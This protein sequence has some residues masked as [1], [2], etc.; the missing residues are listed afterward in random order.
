MGAAKLFEGKFVLVTGASTGIGRCVA[1]DYAREGAE[2]ILA[3]R[4]EDK[5]NRLKEEI[6]A[7]GRRAVVL[8][9]DLSRP[10]E[11]AKLMD[12]ALEGCRRIDIL[13]NNAG[14]GYVEVVPDVDFEKARRMFEINFWSAVEATQRIL[15]HMLKRGS[16]QIINV[17]SIAGKR[18]LPA[19]S[20]YNASKFALEGFTEAL[21]V[22]LYRS[23]IQV[24]SICPSV[25][26]TP[27]FEHPY[28]KD[29][30]LREQSHSLP[31]MSPESVSRGLLRASKKGKRDVHFTWLGWLAVRLNPLMPRLLDWI[32]FRMRGEKVAK[33][34][35][36]IIERSR[37]DS[38]MGS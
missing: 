13:V 19:S 30:P 4:S 29:S 15:P 1:L 24:I 38:G 25:T 12:R 2:L 35:A 14:V 10:G 18:A 22:E 28:V 23:G 37:L 21:R 11:A 8:P 6:E 20:M 34:Y 3:A 33:R 9:V 32:A 7:L 17:S 31:A 5:L 16:G 26:E 36:E 27:F